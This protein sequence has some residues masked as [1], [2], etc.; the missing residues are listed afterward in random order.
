MWQKVCARQRTISLQLNIS[1]K[2][3]PI[4]KH[5]FSEFTQAFNYVCELA[6]HTQEKNGIKLRHATYYSVKE[7][8]KG[9]VSDLIIQ[10][11]TK[12]TEA[13]KSAFARKR[14]LVKALNHMLLSVRS[15]I[16]FTPGR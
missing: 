13:V 11:R 8:Y 15:D 14:P 4:L 10:A 3:A 9:L 5:T 6:W 16:T 1:P 2:Q 7:I 12:A